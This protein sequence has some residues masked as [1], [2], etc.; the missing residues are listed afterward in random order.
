MTYNQCGT[1][2]A[3]FDRVAATAMHAGH[4]TRCARNIW[5]K[6]YTCRQVNEMI[7]LCLVLLTC[8]C[9]PLCTSVPSKVDS[10]VASAAATDAQLAHTA[11]QSLL[12]PTNQSA[13]MWRDGHNYGGYGHRR[14]VQRPWNA[15]GGGYS[16]G[17]GSL[18][19]RQPYQGGDNRGLGDL[20]GVATQIDGMFQ[21]LA[22]R[23]R[24]QRI[25]RVLET[26]ESPA[27]SGPPL[28]A[29][30][31]HRRP[32]LLRRV[33]R[34]DGRLQASSRGSSSKPRRAATAP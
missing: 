1:T 8:I 15:D 2:F 18:P 28:A 33:R 5:E 9:K 27:H 26:V 12:L 6:T 7:Q 34:S 3:G 17:G 13:E 4:P 10:I 16:N 24:M 29:T 22:A 14:A 30:A 20:G 21:S 11:K 19:N 25:S 32:C 31:G 23:N